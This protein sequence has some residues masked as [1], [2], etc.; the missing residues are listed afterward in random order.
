MAE[1]L[2]SKH[3]AQNPNP[4]TDKKKKLYCK[5]GWDIHI[6]HL[7]LILS[8]KRGAYIF[9]PLPVIKWF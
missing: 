2:L 9:F 1:N 5:V 7:V 4:S 6:K 8:Q 3:M